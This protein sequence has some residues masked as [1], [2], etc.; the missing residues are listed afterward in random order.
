MSERTARTCDDPAPH[1]AHSWT[2]WSEMLDGTFGDPPP[3]DHDCP[4]CRSCMVAGVR[5]P[6]PPGVVWLLINGNGHTIAAFH[7][8]VAARD[9]VARMKTDHPL[10]N[11]RVERWSIT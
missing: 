6:V 3:T 9:I 2:D 5:H 7:D 10:T 11:W 1:E 4:G 8:E